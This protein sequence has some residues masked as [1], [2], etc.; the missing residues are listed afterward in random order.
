MEQA[1]MM[2][3]LFAKM[4]AEQ[5][6]YRK[7]LVSLPPEEIL[8]HA[9]EYT[10]REAAL[11]LMG[12]VELS[13]GQITALFATKTP[14]TG[15]CDEFFSRDIDYE[16][17]LTDCIE[18]LR[19]MRHISTRESRRLPHSWNFGMVRSMVSRKNRI[20]KPKTGT[21]VCC[22]SVRLMGKERSMEFE[23]E[24]SRMEKGMRC[25]KWIGMA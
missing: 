21:M 1:E 17:E 16:I 11:S 25:R 15:I 12:K 24:T 2:Q 19:T 18:V 13:K 8:E 4:S 23:K 22:P 14:L 7:W 3:V 20:T 9:Y 6:G 5:G 10:V